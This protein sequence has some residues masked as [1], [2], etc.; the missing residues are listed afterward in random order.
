ML[1]NPCSELIHGACIAIEHGL[2]VEQLQ[3]TVFPHPTVSE[4]LKETIINL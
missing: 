3:E 4:I 1:G 2:T